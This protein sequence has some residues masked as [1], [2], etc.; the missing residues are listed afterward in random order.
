[1]ANT[2]GGI[3][4]AQISEQSLDYLST[5]FHPLRAFSRDFS[6][7]ISGA[8]ESVTTRVPSSMT[9]SDLS[10]G[11]AATDVTSTAITVTLNQ[12]K[13]YSMAFTDME[14]SKAG[15]FDWLSSVFLAPALEVT[16]DAVM[17]SLLA[18]VLNSNFSANEVITAANFDLDEVADL[19]ADLTNVKCPKSDRALVLP[20]AYYASLAKDNLVQ[21]AS[22]YG[23][24]GP[25]Q[26]NIVQ[27][28][29]GFSIYEYTGIP[30]NGENLA[31]IALHPSALCLAARQ[32]AA[33][34]DGSV[35]VSDIVD[36]STGLPIQLRTW[37][38]N[39]AGK[40]YLAMGVLYGVAK[41]NGAALKRIKSA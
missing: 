36:P 21:D 16:L 32:P 33:P 25:I 31:A 30:A 40:H 39:T 24:A 13:G 20:S 14:V 1:M 19:A 17:D 4:I 37:Y 3:N 28:A 29:H 15:N 7:D 11:Y 27:K 9:A 6:A 38:D 26:D 8:G 12:F 2:L 41:G 18:L 34:A 22:A 10:T 23:N 5:Q 35:Q